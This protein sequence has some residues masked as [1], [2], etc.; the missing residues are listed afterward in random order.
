M[1]S[2]RF[3]SLEPVGNYFEIQAKKQSYIEDTPVALG[4]FIL[5]QAKLRM[6][7]FYYSFIQK[8]IGQYKK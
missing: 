4:A 5:N 2:Q 7:E 3:L 8:Y 6:L 1:Q